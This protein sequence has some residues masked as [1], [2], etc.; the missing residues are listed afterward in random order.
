MLKKMVEMLFIGRDHLLS[1]YCEQE[2]C[3][4]FLTVIWKLPLKKK[5]S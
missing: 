5:K 4:N 2:I 1:L 3:Y